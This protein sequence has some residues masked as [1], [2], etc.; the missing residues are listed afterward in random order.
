MV[1]KFLFLFLFSSSLWAQQAQVVVLEAPVFAKP[2]SNSKVV[3]YLRKGQK[4]YIHPSELARDRYDGL[5]DEEHDKIVQFEGNYN[6][7]YPDTFFKNGDTYFPHPSSKFYKTLT[8]SGADGYILKEHIFLLYKDVRELNQ[9]IVKKD[10]TDYRIEEPLPKGFPIAQ[11]TGYRGQF[12]YSMGTPSTSSYPYNEKIDDSGYD[13]NKELIFIWSRHVKWDLNRRFFFG[14]TFYFHS[15][16][17][18]HTTENL[19]T[20]ENVLRVGAGPMLS[21]DAWK[22]DRYAINLNA[23]LTFNFYDNIEIKQ[24]IKSSN[25]SDSR[26]YKANHFTPRLGSQFFIREILSTFDFVMGIN[27]SLELPYTYSSASS[28]EYPQYWQDSFDRD[29]SIQQSYLIGLQSDY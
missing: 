18:K 16:N 1:I 20:T 2:D 15:S 23:S 3:Q 27:L 26:E 6:K 9:K 5:I 19:D 10:P 21:Y 25:V 24:S 28:P 4:I 29:W 11:P 7:N 12:L 14:G 22:T 13:Y 17:V 8:K